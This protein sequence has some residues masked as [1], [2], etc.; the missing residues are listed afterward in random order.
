MLTRNTKG[1]VETFCCSWRDVCWR[2]GKKYQNEHRA[3]AVLQLP[4]NL[5]HT[6]DVRLRQ[7]VLV[8]GV[9]FLQRPAFDGHVYTELRTGK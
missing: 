2:T 3:S 6:E 1:D 5:L 9:L 7:S 4:T 8:S